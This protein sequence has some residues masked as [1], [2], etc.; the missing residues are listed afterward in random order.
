VAQRVNI[1]FVD[2]LTEVW[3][4]LLAGGTLVVLDEETLRDPFELVAAL[5]DHRVTTFYAV[6]SLLRT[7]LEAF[8]ELQERVPDL[9]LL[10][11]SGEP[12][13]PEL[14]R[15][16]GEAL[17]RVTIANVYGATEAA[18]ASAA[19]HA[20]LI[21]RDRIPIGR[22]L[23]NMRVYVLD[24]RLRLCAS[25][26]EGTLY[27]EGPSVATGYWRDACLTAAKFLPSPYSE[28]PGARMYCLGDRG[29]RLADG[30]LEYL[31]RQDGQIKLRGLRIET[32]EIERVIE[33]RAGVAAAC[34][35]AVPTDA[36]ENALVAYVKVE[37]D[38]RV[39]RAS[40]VS[41]IKLHLPDYMH[42]NAVVL[43]DSLPHTTSGKVDRENLRARGLPAQ[44]AEERRGARTATE[45]RLVLIWQDI[46]RVREPS[47]A[48]SFFDLGGHS[49]LAM[50]VVARIREEF[51][52]KLS[53]QDVFRLL[54]IEKVAERLDAQHDVGRAAQDA[55][56]EA[57]VVEVTD[58]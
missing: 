19:E 27:A 14:V 30:S 28:K 15:K 5:A 53:A 7:I 51:G 42:P 49:L 8:P 46:L 4:T 11:L 38:A 32:E 10:V 54:T 56:A 6:P 41:H 26:V 21:G 37:Q 40:V 36:N 48:T 52:I 43:C 57:A 12:L 29:R 50:R 3:A 31:R 2:S 34:V 20:D 45:R 24:D 17:P 9:R 44:A 33:Q 58:F 23:S 1:G 16:L 13:T 25:G 39:D 18:D 55:G 47:V 35:V 22:P